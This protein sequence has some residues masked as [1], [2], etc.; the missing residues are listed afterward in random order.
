MMMFVFLA[1]YKSPCLMPGR[2]LLSYNVIIA[3][4]NTLLSAYE[5]IFKVST[6]KA[7]MKASGDRA[8]AV[9]WEWRLHKEK[10]NKIKAF[11]PEMPCGQWLQEA[12]YVF[13]WDIRGHNRVGLNKANDQAQWPEQKG[14]WLEFIGLAFGNATKPCR[15]WPLQQI[16][17]DR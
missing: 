17:S 9:Q 7:I 5:H 16:T 15:L 8:A 1:V 12:L 2:L 11:P 14:Q 6:K 3:N 13:V 10:K 4:Y